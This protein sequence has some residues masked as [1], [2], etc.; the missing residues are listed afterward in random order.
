MARSR[1]SYPLEFKQE[2]VSLVLKQGCSVAEAARRLGVEPQLLRNWKQLAEANAGELAGS[3]RQPTAIEAEL[4]R[5]R[6]E[7]ERLR[8]ERDILK[9]ATAFFA[10][11]S[12]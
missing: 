1:R 8:M 3:A 11:E 2:A 10:K 4:T 9:K 7:N 12:K 5:L 6:A